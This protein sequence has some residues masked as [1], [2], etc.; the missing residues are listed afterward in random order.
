MIFVNLPGIQLNTYDNPELIHLRPGVLT[1]TMM[2]VKDLY[3]EL[4]VWYCGISTA[5]SLKLFNIVE[6]LGEQFYNQVINQ[7]VSIL[8]DLPFEP[9]LECIDI[10]YEELVVKYNISPKQIIF[11]SN[12]FDANDYNLNLANKL[13]LDPIRT[14]FVPTL[15][16][17]MN[18]EM[19]HNSKFKVDTLQ[20][21]TY[22]KKF[23]NFN[24]RWRPHRPMMTLLLKHFDLLKDGFVS[25]GPCEH[26]SK[27]EEI[28][29][30]LIVSSLGNQELFDIVQSNRDIMTMPPLYL[31]TDNLSINRPHPESET[32]VYYENSYYSLISET[33]FYS[34]DPG[35]SSRFITEKT[36]KAILF[37]HPFIL[38]SIPNS[39]DVLKFLGY[40][41]FHP[42]IDESYDKELDDNKRLLMIVKEV[43]RLCNLS[44]G[45]RLKFL[46]ACRDIVEFNYQVLCDKKRFVYACE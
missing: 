20:N 22:E 1:S 5:N 46:N 27:W 3:P 44:N 2:A 28:F 9:F 12:M 30:G 45:D 41:T 19:N 40:K 24:R 18:W 13:S 32:N 42:W 33:T 6:L 4:K 37:K 31:D 25:F 39:L 36:F 26:H 11:A 23:L 21:K 43:K 14:L 8:I 7:E 35:V 34:K 15:E 29:D 16:F 10:I 17:M 38:I